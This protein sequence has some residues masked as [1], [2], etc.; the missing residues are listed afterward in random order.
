MKNNDN[1]TP[2]Y[3]TIHN[4]K[5]IL[6]RL[7]LTKIDFSTINNSYTY[8]HKAIRMRDAAL[9]ERLIEMGINVNESDDQG[10]LLLIFIF[11]KY[12]RFHLFSHTF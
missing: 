12:F 3:L 4:N 2:L 10:N 11:I 7:I 5:T 1:K 6:T 9:A 8:L